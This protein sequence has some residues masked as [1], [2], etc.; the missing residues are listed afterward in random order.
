MRLANFCLGMRLAKIYRSFGREEL[1][2]QTVTEKKMERNIV[3]HCYLKEEIHRAAVDSSFP[4]RQQRHLERTLILVLF[5][6]IFVFFFRIS[7]SF[8]FDQPVLF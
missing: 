8:G 3:T 7:V 1:G 2:N 4:W 6:C 5:L